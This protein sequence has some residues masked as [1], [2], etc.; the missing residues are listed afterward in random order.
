MRIRLS[1]ALALAVLLGT[2]AFLAPAASAESTPSEFSSR[3][4]TLLNQARSEHGLATLTVTSGT[5]TVAQGWTQHLDADQSLS[6]N[7]DLG[8]QLEAHGS[9]QWTACGE[10]VGEGPTSSADTLFQAYMNSPEHR[11]NILNPKYRYLGV[12]VVF[13]GSTAWNTLDFVDQ[14]STSSSQ[15]RTKPHTA[16]QSTTTT[17]AK[18]V[19]RSTPRSTLRPAARP[20]TTVQ[21]AVSRPAVQRTTPAPRPA[22]VRAVTSTAPKA[23]PLAEPMTTLTAA[24]PVSVRLPGSPRDTAPFAAA[25]AAILLIV[26]TRWFVEV[27]SRR[28]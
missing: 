25:A 28:A 22:R 3:L 14:Y 16:T 2:A 26:A 18:P 5:S 17:A 21:H 4:V 1:A 7:P 27:R 23:A 15:P 8:S 13:D 6:H 12:G 24:L 20:I 11:D 9:P 10:N 19:T